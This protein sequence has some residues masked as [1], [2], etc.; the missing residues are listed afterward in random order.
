MAH[1]GISIWDNKHIQVNRSFKTFNTI[2]NGGHTN[3]ASYDFNVV[4]K[5]IFQIIRK[6]ILNWFDRAGVPVTNKDIK[7]FVSVLSYNLH[8]SFLN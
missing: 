6:L 8:N 4:I 3:K 7:Y 1:Y 2:N 5:L